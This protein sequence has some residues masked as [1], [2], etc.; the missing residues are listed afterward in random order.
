MCVIGLMK[1]K[2]HRD[3]DNNDA[4]ERSVKVKVQ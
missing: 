1:Q 3:G 4:M 2:L